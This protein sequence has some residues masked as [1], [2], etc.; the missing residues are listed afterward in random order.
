M[1]GRDHEQA[2]RTVGISLDVDNLLWAIRYRVYH[3]LSSQ[4]HGFIRFRRD[5]RCMMRTFAPLQR[6]KTSLKW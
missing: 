5:T 1:K 4:D 6:A 2:L 3:Q